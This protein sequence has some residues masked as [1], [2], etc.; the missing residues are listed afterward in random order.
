MALLGWFIFD[1][2]RNRQHIYLIIA[3]VLVVLEDES[4]ILSYQSNH[5]K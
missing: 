1:Q 4:E 2:L 3:L 5:L